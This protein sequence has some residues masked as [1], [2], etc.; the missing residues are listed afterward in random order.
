MD[1]LN[2][3]SRITGR[4]VKDLQD[5]FSKRNLKAVRSEAAAKSSAKLDPINKK[6]T[7]LIKN[8]VVD[9]ETIKKTLNIS[10]DKF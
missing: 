7:D 2:D 5:A 10:E 3:L 8:N 9:K 1:A 4:S 6:L